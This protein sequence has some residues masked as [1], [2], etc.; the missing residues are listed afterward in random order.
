MFNIFRKNKKFKSSLENQIDV[1]KELDISFN[2]SDTSLLKHLTGHFSREQYEEDPYRLLISIAGTDLLDINDNEIRLSDDILSFDTECVEE[3]NIYTEVIT[4]F[5]DITR[6]DLPL[7]NIDSKVDFEEETAYISFKYENDTTHW[8]V[9]FDD[10]WFDV[11]IFEKLAKLVVNR[12]KSFI[13][14]N[15]GQNLTIL[16]CTSPVFKKL[17]ELTNNQFKLLA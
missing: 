2:E 12:E 6:G 5:I 8:E 4:R 10:D 14:F 15:D 1:L 7:R 11:S 3:E 16:Y 13:F 9:N 17:N